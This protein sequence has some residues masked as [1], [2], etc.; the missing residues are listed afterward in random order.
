MEQLM[1]MIMDLWVL[2]CRECGADLPNPQPV[3]D[4]SYWT[5]PRGG[6]YWEASISIADGDGVRSHACHGESYASQ[7]KAL[8]H[9]TC[10]MIK[11][12]TCK[13]PAV[14]HKVQLLVDAFRPPPAVQ[15]T[16][17]E[18]EKT[19]LRAGDKIEAIKSYRKRTQMGLADAK[20]VIEAFGAQ[21]F[22]AR[23]PQS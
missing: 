7:K 14:F 20:A 5:D 18:D 11:D 12:S 10:E 22:L 17:T 4:L 2:I 6:C 13:D 3:I 8:W 21:E 16:L 9:L 19:S 23:A 15:Y 1:D